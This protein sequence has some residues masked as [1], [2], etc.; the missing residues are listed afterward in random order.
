MCVKGSWKIPQV[1]GFSIIGL[2]Y[3][4]KISAVIGLKILLC[5]VGNLGNFPVKDVPIVNG[6][7]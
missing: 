1:Y 2:T 5:I 3:L 6:Q 4:V 7:K